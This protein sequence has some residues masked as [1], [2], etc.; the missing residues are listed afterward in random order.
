M[1]PLLLTSTIPSS[2]TLLLYSL[3]QFPSTA[4]SE[5]DDKHLFDS[6]VRLKMGGGY[7]SR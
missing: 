1:N 5:V 7:D 3:E 4:V 2:S 6:E